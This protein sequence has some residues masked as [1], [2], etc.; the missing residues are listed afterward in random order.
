MGLILVQRRRPWQPGTWVLGWGATTAAWSTPFIAPGCHAAGVREDWVDVAKGIAIVLV[1]AFHAVVFPAN[2]GLAQD[3]R[4]VAALLDTFRMP[5]FFFTS[6]LFAA[7]A[8]R[9]PLNE[10][11]RTRVARLLWLFVL[12]SVVWFAVFYLAP[13]LG[14]SR[15]GQRPDELALM[16]F[17]P[18]QNTWYVYALALYL[19]VAWGLRRVPVGVQIGLAALLA[20]A[21]D[22]GLLDATNGAVDRMGRGFVWFLV[23]VHLGPGV[24]ALAPRVRWWHPLLAVALYG[25]AASL[26]AVS[27]VI[28]APFV[29]LTLAALAVLGGCALAVALSRV[30]ALGWLRALGRR[31]LGVYLVHFYVI[32]GV[33]LLLAPVAAQVA[34][35]RM[36]D[37]AL[38]VL[39]TFLAVPV[40]L[41]VERLTRRIT[42]LWDRPRLQRREAHAALPA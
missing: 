13:P 35:R 37:L 25:G 39:L 10:L 22:V 36:L 12:W 7:R 32:L 4:G 16:F 3:W 11:W 21:F 27:G 19:L 28:G 18:N 33:C 31:T 5:L 17:S 38:P 9:R 1:V 20:V 23:A 14:T 6:G 41:C 26:V 40:S 24:R 29:R 8:L 15:V 42:W 30:A 2:R 34:E